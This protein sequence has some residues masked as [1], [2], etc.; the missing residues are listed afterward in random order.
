MVLADVQ[1]GDELTE[2]L[3]GDADV[4]NIDIF[5]GNSSKWAEHDRRINDIFNDYLEY[6]YYS[7]I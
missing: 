2:T 3:T 7:E 5:E 4:S 6:G 1:G